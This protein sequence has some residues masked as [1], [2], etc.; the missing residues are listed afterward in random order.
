MSFFFIKELLLELTTKSQLN[1][2]FCVPYSP[3]PPE[4]VVYIQ[5]TNFLWKIDEGP[6]L[7]QVVP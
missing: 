1:F 3:F 4:G 2:I 7:L 6:V 5:G